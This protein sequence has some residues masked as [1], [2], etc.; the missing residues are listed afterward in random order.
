MRERLGSKMGGGGVDLSQGAIGKTLA[1]EHGVGVNSNPKAQLEEHLERQSSA[2]VPV[3]EHIPDSWETQKRGPW[4]QRGR[5]E[6]R[7]IL[8]QQG[9]RSYGQINCHEFEGS[10]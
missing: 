6:G 3:S 8:R 9:C 5:R 1:G 2:K 7:E 10:I 4:T